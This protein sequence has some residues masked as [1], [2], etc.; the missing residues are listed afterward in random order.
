MAKAL[1][2]EKQQKTEKQNKK[3]K[4]KDLPGEHWWA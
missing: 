3:Q 2:K 4:S 1:E